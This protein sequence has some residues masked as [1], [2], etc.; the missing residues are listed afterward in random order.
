[1]SDL[2]RHT[3]EN[4]GGIARIWYA[5]QSETRP[6]INFWNEPPS[7]SQLDFDSYFHEIE[8]EKFKAFASSQ[9]RDTPSGLVWPVNL[10]IMLYK[11]RPEIRAELRQI[12]HRKIYL[13]IIDQNGQGTFFGYMQAA[14]VL[15]SG[16]T[17]GTPFGDTNQYDFQFSAELPVQP[18]DLNIID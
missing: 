2:K 7:I 16:H 12:D 3:G 15:L 1:M 11:D 4:L 17:T 8:F 6:F 14:L 5:F 18:S 10:G 9:P 13:Y